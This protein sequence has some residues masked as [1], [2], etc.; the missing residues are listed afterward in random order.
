[1]I[2][3]RESS[4][5]LLIR[6]KNKLDRE[7]EH[8]HLFKVRIARRFKLRTRKWAVCSVVLN[9]YFIKQSMEAYPKRASI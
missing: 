5:N 3:V 2:P 1:M 8:K 6:W 4:N 9:D 7:H